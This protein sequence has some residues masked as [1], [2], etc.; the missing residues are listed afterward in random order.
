MAS[1]RATRSAIG[2]QT[3]MQQQILDAIL[4]VEERV[5]YLTERA[6]AAELSGPDSVLLEI[7]WRNINEVING[8]N[9][10]AKAQAFHRLMMSP[11]IAPMQVHFV[12]DMLDVLC[13][14]EF[15]GRFYLR[16][17]PG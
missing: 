2:D 13:S 11:I 12:S 14:P 3:D 1:H 9:S 10:P 8:L 15:R 7:P 5:S 16:K 17:P 4:R 6:R